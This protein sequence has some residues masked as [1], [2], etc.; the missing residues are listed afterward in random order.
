MIKKE[1]Y[2][3]LKRKFGKNSS[4]TIWDGPENGNWKSK[5]NIGSLQCF[6]NEDNLLKKLN[7]NYIFVGF[8]PAAHDNKEVE[9]KI[10]SNFHSSDI[11]RSQDYK[12][13]YALNGTKYWGSF[14]TDVYPEIVETDSTK[15]SSKASN[16]MI[17]ESIDNLI[18]VRE[19]L[20]NEAT[21]VAIGDAAYKVIKNNLPKDVKL[22]K[23]MH[24]SYQSINQEDYRNL[25]LKQ[26]NC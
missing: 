9:K 4:W 2:I 18:Y 16:N 24:Y 11:K 14:I 7:P 26:L 25:V 8:N 10:W 5:S 6:E 13:R 1:I 20:G 17:N 23:I 15:V 22:I 12:L 3:K 19:L 21:I